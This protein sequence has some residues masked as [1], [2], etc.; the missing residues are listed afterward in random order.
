MRIWSLAAAVI[1]VLMN[2]SATLG[3]DRDPSLEGAQKFCADKYGD[4]LLGVS[5]DG[6][7]GV[8]CKFAAVTR[9]ETFKL[10]SREPE[11]K[12]AK[13]QPAWDLD[14]EEDSVTGGNGSGATSTAALAP[15][16]A[17]LPSQAEPKTIKKKRAS[18]R[19]YK[20]RRT[21]RRRYRRRNRDPF[22]A[23]FR[24]ARKASVRRKARRHVRRYRTN[25]RRRRR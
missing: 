17:A 6:N 1:L 2:I 16:L 4:R 13:A 24:N 5:L 11:P 7:A 14:A 18:K 3:E 19:R 23:L 15:G 12:V 22:A 25:V 10:P 20:K 9:T 21:K 8:S